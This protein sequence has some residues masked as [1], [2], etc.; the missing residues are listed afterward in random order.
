MN[1]VFHK[2]LVLCVVGVA[3]V[4]SCEDDTSRPAKGDGEG[5]FQ[6]ILQM[7]RNCIITGGDTTDFLPRPEGFI[8][9]TVV[10]PHGGPPTNYSLIGACPNPSIAGTEIHWQ[11]PRPDSVWILAFDAPGAPPIDTLYNRS[12]RTGS[13]IIPWRPAQP[14][15]Y[16][17]RMFTATGFK[18]YGDVLIEP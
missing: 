13:Y 14:G 2:I 12:G 6:G 5:P 16:R 8:D 11:I 15:F 9:T 7:D 4:V 17:I 1:Q 18:S 3:L 10:P